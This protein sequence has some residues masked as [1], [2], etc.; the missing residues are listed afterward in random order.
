LLAGAPESPPLEFPVSFKSPDPARAKSSPLVR[1][2]RTVSE[3]SA[4]ALQAPVREVPH[5]PGVIRVQIGTASGPISLE[6][7]VEWA[8]DM[9]VLVIPT[10]GTKKIFSGAAWKI[11]ER[12][13][14]VLSSEQASPPFWL[15]DL[16]HELGHL[17]LGHPDERGVVDI[18]KPGEPIDDA[19]EEEANR[20]ALDLLL[21][22]SEEL[23]VEIRRRCEGSLDWQKRKFKWKVI[24]VAE[25][26][27]VD[28]ALLATTAAYALRDIAK[29]VDRWGSAQNIAKEQGKGRTIV[30]EALRR[31]IDLDLLPELD[32]ALLRVVVLE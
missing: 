32:A 13:V 5:D 2:A 3:I 1:L 28:K 15:F 22:K 14:A 31:R 8:W 19:H 7:L 30:Q 16:A 25:E 26:A 9:G 29:P 12:P 6:A 18:D 21:P 4:G 20:F 27:G 17:A 23:L 24:E 10:P 11:G